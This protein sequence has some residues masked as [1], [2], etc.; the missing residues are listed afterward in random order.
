MNPKDYS[1]ITD[2]IEWEC[3]GGCGIFVSKAYKIE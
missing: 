1:S 2:V 3:G